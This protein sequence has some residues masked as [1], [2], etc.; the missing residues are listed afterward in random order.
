MG[1]FAF[2]LYLSTKE[3]QTRGVRM[4]GVSVLGFEASLPSC[5]PWFCNWEWK[6]PKVTFEKATTLL[7]L[8][9]L[10]SVGLGL[11][12]QRPWESRWLMSANFLD[13]AALSPFQ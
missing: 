11:L 5:L 10:V 12:S 2:L 1:H 13:S 6:L 3:H 8:P 7:L 4:E 9:V